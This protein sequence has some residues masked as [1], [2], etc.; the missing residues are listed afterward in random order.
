MPHGLQGIN[1]FAAQV[2]RLAEIALCQAFYLS[3]QELLN[4]VALS[5]EGLVGGGL[6]VV[7]RKSNF[8]PPEFDS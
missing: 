2:N 7:R 1:W 6:K 5:N 3:G 8:M 4:G